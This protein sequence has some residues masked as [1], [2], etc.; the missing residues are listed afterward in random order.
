M[1]DDKTKSVGRAEYL[2]S[3]R[4][5]P[6][7]AADLVN[8]CPLYVSLKVSTGCLL[9]IIGLDYN[10]SGLIKRLDEPDFSEEDE[11]AHNDLGGQMNLTKQELREIMKEYGLSEI[12]KT[13]K[14][15]SRAHTLSFGY[16]PKDKPAGGKLYLI[17][18]RPYSA[19]DN[20]YFI[21]ARSFAAG[22]NASL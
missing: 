20:S 11:D 15:T 22:D 16:K 5:N 18:T 1:A 21:D 13:E 7:V 8:K 2:R 6:K 3:I 9:A 19:G 4:D 12:D 14:R 10:D 17:D